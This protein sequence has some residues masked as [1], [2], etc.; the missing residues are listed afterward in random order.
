MDIGIS[1]DPEVCFDDEKDGM[2]S[3]L[4]AID[5]CSKF[6]LLTAA[7]EHI[8]ALQSTKA[9]CSGPFTRQ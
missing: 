9:W 8:L 1:P 6:M 7:V 2:H 4:C 5:V 3:C